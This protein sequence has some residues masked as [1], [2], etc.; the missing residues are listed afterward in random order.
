MRLLTLSILTRARRVLECSQVL[1]SS[2]TIGKVFPLLD[3]AKKLAPGATPQARRL[4]L[5]VVGAARS[6]RGRHL[7]K[8]LCLGGRVRMK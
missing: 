4:L 8:R 1:K 5:C 2:I 3:D 6:R 7:Q